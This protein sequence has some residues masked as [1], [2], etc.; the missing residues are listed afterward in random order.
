MT[1][2]G[3]HSAFWSGRVAAKHLTAYV[4]GEIPDL[5]AYQR[6]VERELVMQLWVSRRF[7]DLFH[8][9]PAL[10]FEGRAPYLHSVEARLPYIARRA[11]LYKRDEPTQP[12]KY[13]NRLRL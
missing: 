2:E 4:G 6:E 11:D 7:H 3:I 8:L 1:D 10:F 9:S 13:G 5:S 12:D